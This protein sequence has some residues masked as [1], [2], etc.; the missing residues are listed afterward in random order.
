[1]ILLV[2]NYDSFTFN[3][4]QLLRVAAGDGLDLRVVESDART[5]DQLLALKPSHVVLSPGPRGPREAGV[6]VALAARCPVPLLGVCLGHQ[7]L[8]TAFGAEV[9][10]APRPVHGQ[11]WAVHHDGR[12]VFTAMAAGFVAARYHSLA[13]D[14]T[15][16][17]PALEVA[18]TTDDGVIMGLRHRE[19]PLAG[20]QFHPESVLTDGGVTLVRNFLDGHI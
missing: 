3:L 8:A 12:G 16:V 5:V 2:D 17:P 1:M 7:C 15:S 4:A 18:A 10:R 11:P 6:S 9:R 14:P 20:V 19:R 13:V